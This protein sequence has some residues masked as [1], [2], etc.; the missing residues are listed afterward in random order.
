MKTSWEPCRV[1]H[2]VIST[3][4]KSHSLP[5]QTNPTS[6][7]SGRIDIESTKK[8]K[9]EESGAF[10]FAREAE[11]TTQKEEAEEIKGEGEKA[12]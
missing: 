3:C 9:D 2:R 10:G 8:K 12:V 4:C 11:V 6:S 5:A 7:I 1:I